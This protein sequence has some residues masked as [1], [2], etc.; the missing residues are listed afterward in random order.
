MHRLTILT[1]EIFFFKLNFVYSMDSSIERTERKK[2][3]QLMKSVCLSL[4]LSFTNIL[5]GHRTVKAFLTAEGCTRKGFYTPPKIGLEMSSKSQIKISQINTQHT[6]W[7]HSV[8][9]ER[10]KQ[11]WTIIVVMSRIKICWMYLP[12]YGQ[13]AFGIWGAHQNRT[14]NIIKNQINIWECFWV[15]YS[16]FEYFIV[17]LSTFLVLLSTFKHF[18]HYSNFSML[19]Y[20]LAI[21][22]I[23]N[24]F[25]AHF[26]SI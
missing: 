18:W 8:H 26:L 10:T 13:K 11:N 24:Q 5:K 3:F 1:S 14:I 9:E 21:F 20:N 22:G 25:L 15:F 16:V 7:Q 23:L 12:T 4:F 19:V 2:C 17:L 6:D